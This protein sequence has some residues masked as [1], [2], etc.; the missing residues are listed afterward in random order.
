MCELYSIIEK[1]CEEKGVNITTMC[2]ESGANRGTLTDLKMGRRK[3]V[4]AETAQKIASYF[5]VTVAY[6]L[7]E[8]EQKEKPTV[9]DD[10][11]TDGEKLLLDMF[12]RIPPEQQQVFL[13][14]GRVY[15]NSLKKD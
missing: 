14:M 3:G 8:E 6:L 4:N 11:L 2:R 15:A 10:G 9:M 12:R 5:G 7:G 1:L 13:E